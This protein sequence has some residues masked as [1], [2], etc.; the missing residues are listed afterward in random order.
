MVRIA[1]S[2]RLRYGPDLT[3]AA[4]DWVKAGYAYYSTVLP[5]CSG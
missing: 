4:T 5:C 2:A 3:E 1:L